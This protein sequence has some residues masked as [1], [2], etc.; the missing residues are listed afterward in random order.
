MRGGAETSC[1]AAAPMGLPVGRIEERTMNFLQILQT[2]LQLATAGIQ[3]TNEI[4]ALVQAIEAPFGAG[5]LGP[6]QHRACV[7]A[8]ET[9]GMLHLRRLVAHRKYITI[10]WVRTLA[11]C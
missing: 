9:G 6:G 10:S 4:L 11:R 7:R 5:I 3:L 8:S 1:C 2:I